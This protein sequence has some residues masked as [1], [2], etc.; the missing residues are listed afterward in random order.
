MPRAGHSLSCR[1]GEPTAGPYPDLATAPGVG[2]AGANRQSSKEAVFVD[3]DAAE[4]LQELCIPFGQHEGQA[5]HVH[6]YIV[7]TSFIWGHAPARSAS[8]EASDGYAV[9]RAIAVRV[10]EQVLTC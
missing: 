3:V 1:W 7:F 5:V 6:F 8:A 4:A 9:D 2:A 10:L